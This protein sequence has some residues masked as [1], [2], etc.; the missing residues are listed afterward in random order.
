MSAYGIR[1]R[2]NFPIP[3]TSILNELCSF[4]CFTFPTSLPFCT[5]HVFV[6][7]RFFFFRRIVVESFVLVLLPV[8][9][10]N[11]LFLVSKHD[12]RTCIVCCFF[13]SFLSSSSSS[14]LIQKVNRSLCVSSFV[15]FL[16]CWETIRPSQKN[17]VF[18]IWFGTFVCVSDKKTSRGYRKIGVPLFVF[19]F[20]FLS[21]CSRKDSSSVRPKISC[22]WIRFVPLWFVSNPVPSSFQ[23][24]FHVFSF[25]PC[26]GKNDIDFCRSR[27]S[28]SVY[29]G[30]FFLFLFFFFGNGFLVENIVFQ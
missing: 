21:C 22:V 29:S 18:L 20:L 27:I 4:V 10:C 1:F 23:S 9:C 17:L 12:R 24:V 19:C 5:L 16:S 7:F 13:R 14:E 6:L 28:F 8:P 11:L 26:C 3:C 25:L 2:I 15:S 30:S